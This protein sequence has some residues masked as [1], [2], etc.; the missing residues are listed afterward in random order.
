MVSRTTLGAIALMAELAALPAIAG[1]PPTERE[2]VREK[3]NG[4][5]L[6]DPYR[7]LE[8]SAA[9]EVESPDGALDAR[10]SA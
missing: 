8:G 4:V 9:P 6:T 2:P 1:V 3:L 7:W 5:E 10:V